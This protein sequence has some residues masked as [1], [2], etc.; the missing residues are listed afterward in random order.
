MWQWKSPDDGQRKCLKHVDFYSKNK[1]EKLVHLL[2]F[3]IRI[4]HDERSPEHNILSKDFSY[5]TQYLVYN[6]TNVKFRDINTILLFM[7]SFYLCNHPDDGLLHETCCWLRNKLINITVFILHTLY[8]MIE[9]DG[10]NFVRLY[11]LNCKWYVNDIHNIWN[12]KSYVF[13]YHR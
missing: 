12:R 1:F 6:N 11:F 10:L 8:R 4:F 9:K 5:C 2:G 7:F 13:R 3:I